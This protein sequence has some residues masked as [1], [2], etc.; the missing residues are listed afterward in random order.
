ML[1]RR[2]VLLSGLAATGSGLAASGDVFAQS[3]DYPTEV[4]HAICPFAPGSGADV[5]VRFYLNSLARKLNKTMVVDNR[6]GAQGLIATEQAARAKPDGY[7]LFIAPG[8][9]VL[10]AAPSLYKS[11]RFDPMKDFEHITTL[12]SSAFVLCVAGSSPFHSLSD[13]TAYLRKQGS[14]ASYGSIAPSG[15]VPSEIYKS[16]YGLETVEVKYKEQSAMF[17]DLFSNVISF[18]FIDY[19]PAMGQIQ[20]GQVRALSLACAEPLAAIPGVPGAREAGIPDC[21]VRSWWS[22]HVPAK[23]PRPICDKLELWFNEIAV[24]PETR[25]FSLENGAD[26]LPGTSASL[27]QLLAKEIKDWEGYAKLAHIEPS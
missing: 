19:I 21:D 27:R 8:S 3:G 25:K 20:S 26:P 17:I 12:S 24:A 15:L 1:N 5:K 7:T 23:T 6:A 16:K 18:M 22:V 14:K 11:L 2:D 9:S 10:A 4:V 13:L